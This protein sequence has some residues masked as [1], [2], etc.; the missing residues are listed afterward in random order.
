MKFHM[1]FLHERASPLLLLLLPLAVLLWMCFQVEGSSVQ[2]NSTFGFG[3][4]SREWM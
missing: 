1:F 3:V 4:N 2:M